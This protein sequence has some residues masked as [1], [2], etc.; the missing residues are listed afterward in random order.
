MVSSCNISK[1]N[2]D[3]CRN[4]TQSHVLVLTIAG[5]KQGG[6]GR[7]QAYVLEHEP[8]AMSAWAKS[9]FIAQ[10]FYG[11]L[12]PLAKSSILLLYLRLFSIHAWFRYTTYGLLAYV[13][14]WGISEALVSIFQCHPVAY[15]W[16]K[17]LNGTCI[18]QLSYYRWV[19]LPNVIHDVIM[20]VLPLPVV[21]KLQTDARRKIALT[22][23]F[24]IGS[25]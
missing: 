6:V 3:S 9:L 21:W 1:R 4:L 14:L 18:D 20:L 7:H 5:V 15:Q 11:I 22:V 17:K 10:F 12:I 8:E 19:S 13:W 24:L 25:M 23:V 2:G 16:D